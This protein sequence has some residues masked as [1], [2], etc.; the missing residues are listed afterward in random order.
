M[1][2]RSKGN[3]LI[4]FLIC[5][6]IFIVLIGVGS[7]AQS[8]NNVDRNQKEEELRK[9]FAEVKKAVQTKD[10]NKLRNYVSK[11]DTLY[12][13]QCNTDTSINFTFNN[14]IHELREHSKNEE[15]TVTEHLTSFVETEGWTGE[16][17]YLYFQFTKVNK[18]WKWLGVCYDMERS[19][20]YRKELGGKEK[21]YD[22]PPKLPR[23]GPR[24]FKDVTA[25]NARIVEILRFKAFD[26]LKPYA[27]EG[28]LLVGKSCPDTVDSKALIKSGVPAD[29]VIEF[30]ITNA[31]SA[32]E[33]TPEKGYSY[34]S[35]YF[36]TAGWSGEKP[37]ITF[38]FA[39]RKKG[40]EWVGV[41]Y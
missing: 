33:I 19:L 26:A 29:Q 39:E 13:G 2:S 20:D 37:K 24:V 4:M 10:F 21:Y 14:I 41:T 32:K 22:S 17:P 34:K 7:S 31:T 38:C 30:L 9:I 3:T 15:I 8:N 12:W 18:N 25:L 23:Q 40:W 1:K 27:T 11:K 36:V 16:Y 35:K 6:L 28:K 5:P